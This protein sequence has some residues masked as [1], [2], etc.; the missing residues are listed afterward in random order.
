MSFFIWLD[1][2]MSMPVGGSWRRNLGLWWGRHL[3]LRHRGVTAPKTCSFHP[4]ARINPRQ[5][6]IS[7]GDNCTVAPG[8]TIQ[9]NISFGDD[10]SVQTGSVLVGYSKADATEGRIRIGNQVRIAPGVMMI[11]ADHVFDNPDVPIHGQGMRPGDIVIGDDVWIAGRVQVMAGVT[12]GTGS[13]IGAGAVV[14][15]DIPPYSVAV[16]I[17]AVVVK[18]RG[19]ARV[20]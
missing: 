8:A 17:P 11:A 6:R 9:G 19:A 2:G 1:G 14:T 3:A 18:Q 20:A 15:R 12:I 7:F 10:C 5:G 4:E 16:G 13:V